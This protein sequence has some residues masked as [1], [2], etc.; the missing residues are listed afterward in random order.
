[1]R[2]ARLA[3]LLWHVLRQQVLRRRTP[4]RWAKARDW[5]YPDPYT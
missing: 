3:P 2:R 1:M 5:P 4:K